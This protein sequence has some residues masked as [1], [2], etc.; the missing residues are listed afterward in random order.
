MCPEI[1][2]YK[3]WFS[4]VIT[5]TS[6]GYAMSWSCIFIVVSNNSIGT[7]NGI[8]TVLKLRLG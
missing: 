8:L 7:N 2:L 6:Y 1:K 5:T 4:Y 3:K